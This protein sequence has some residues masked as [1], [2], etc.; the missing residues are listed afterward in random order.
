MRQIKTS[1]WAVTIGSILLTFIIYHLYRSPLLPQFEDQPITPAVEKNHPLVASGDDDDYRQMKHVF[2][3]E[4]YK[5]SVENDSDYSIEEEEHAQG[6]NMLATPGCKIPLMVVPYKKR[7]RKSKIEPCGQR[8]VF[9]T[10]SGPNHVRV[11]IKDELLKRNASYKN[12]Y[13]CIRF[14]MKPEYEYED[15]SEFSS[16]NKCENGDTFA[17]QSDFINVQCFGYDSHNESRV[18][19]DDVYA[20]C[21]KKKP[22]K[23]KRKCDERYNILLLGMDSMSLPRFAQTMTDTMSFMNNNFWL[24]Y[25]GY[26]K[27]DDNTFPN[28][29]AMLTGL[30]FQ[31]FSDKCIGQMDSCNELLI[32][33]AFKHAGYITA[34]G[35]DYVSLPDTFSRNFTFTTKPTDHYMKPFFKLAERSKNCEGTPYLCS[36]KA[37]SGQ[38]LLD[39]AYDF[40]MNYRDDPFFGLFWMNSFSHNPAHRPEDADKMYEDFLNR[41]FYTGVLKNTFVIFFSDHGV[42][43]GKDRL[44][45][46]G[47]YDDRMPILFV[48]PPTSFKYKNPRKYQALVINQFRLVTPYD[49]SKTIGEV[50]RISQGKEESIEYVRFNNH[51]ST[52]DIIPGNRTCQDVF[53]SE[54][55]CS[56]HKLYPLS[57]ND[58]EGIKA[59]EFIS[60]YI[61][62][63][64]TSV[65]T[66]PC[67]SCININLDTILRIHFYSDEDKINL[68][69]VMAIKMAPGD[70]VYEATVMRRGF[71][72]EVVGTVNIISG[73][74]GLGSCTISNSYKDRIFCVCQNEC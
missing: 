2:L 5:N 10:R 27:V 48:L 11:L 9:L 34:Y 30:R 35:E 67:T 41:L 1:L 52:F 59:I 69:Y 71:E 44:N 46:E 20:F 24:N 47:Y 43:F 40:A 55:W 23:R 17:L 37:T 29:I 14:Y 33:T 13:C 42:R 16:C 12:H 45:V 28:L 68:Y 72:M 56:C 39:Y 38:Q 65:I 26:H 51:Q 22:L 54:K 63:K 73:Y 32:W 50:L 8:I 6:R 18:I 74:K 19:Y 66:K 15:G 49:M 21:K 70:M 53:I 64:T 57:E 7:V 58:V 31:V 4:I 61:Q 60:R 3:D 62:N 25:R 36:G